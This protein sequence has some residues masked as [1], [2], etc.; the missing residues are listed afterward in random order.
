MFAYAGK[1]LRVDLSKSKISEEVLP[2]NTLRKFLGGTGIA[3]KYL[4]DEM[5]K[6]A[7]PL[8]PENRLIF[9][10]G[11]LGA[12]I[13]PSAGR[14][15]VCGKSPLTGFWGHG[16]SGGYWGPALK[17]AGFDGI[18]LQGISPEPVYLLIDDGKVEIKDA[19]RL[20]GK[21]VWETTA[22]ITG[23]HGNDFL[24]C[25]IGQAGEKLVKYACP[26]NDNHRAAGRTG[27]GAVMGSKRLKAIAVRGT[28]EV[29]VANKKVFEEVANKNINLINESMLKSVFETFGTSG[30]AEMVNARGGYP[31]RNWQTGVSPHI[32]KIGGPSMR[33]KVLVDIKHCFSCP[34]SCGRVTAVKE[35]PYKITGE[36]PEYESVG[37]FG[38]MCAIADPEAITYLNN[39]CDNYG[40]DTLSA[41]STIAFAMECFEKGILTKSDTEGLELRFGYADVVVKLLEKIAKREGFGD[42][43]AEGSMRMSKKLGRETESFAMHVKGLELPQYDPRA[44]K[45]CGLGYATST[46]GGCHISGYVQ[47]PTFLDIPFLVIPDSKIADPLVSNPEEVHVLRDLQDAFAVFDSSGA[48]KFMGMILATEE[49][50]NMLANATGWEFDVA[51]FRVLGDRIWN[52]QKLFDVREGATRTDDTLPKRL[53]KEPMPEGPAKGHV[54][55][56]FDDL[57]DAYYEIR[58]W[59]K[60]TS[61]PTPEKLGQLGLQEYEYIVK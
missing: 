43:L 48:C 57:L 2:E 13:A 59:N 55:D 22:L 29:E 61:I 31:T 16:N 5:K 6:G 23:E 33:E 30:V 21:G 4:L 8:G 32:E 46:R 49:W 58:Q 3:T 44:A 9:M 60:K 28:K 7:D 56:R 24:V 15:S 26:I 41:G 35:G 12:T 14:Y 27:M 47:G 11:P 52:A 37:A 38:G 40:L 51:E 19:K 34:I 17:R 50:C 25:C 1:I 10:N 20:W 54:V 18:I 53:L 36:G 39:L 45:M 42:I